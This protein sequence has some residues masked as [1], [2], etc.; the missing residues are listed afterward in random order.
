[1]RRYARLVVAL[2]S[3]TT[4]LVGGCGG[5]PAGGGWSRAEKNAEKTYRECVETEP[6]LNEIIG[7]YVLSDQTVI[8]GGLSAL[9]GRKCQ[10]DVLADGTFRVTDYP[11]FYAIVPGKS[12]TF[13]SFISTTGRWRLEVIMTS[14]YYGKKTP[15]DGWGLRFSGATRRISTPVFTGPTRPYGLLMFLGDPDSYFTLRFKRQQAGNLEEP[16]GGA[17][18]GTGS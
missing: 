18:T 4:V 9:G 8:P 3:M 10:L 2:L 17:G 14:D 1:M 12:T 11:D 7:T 5:S 6:Q 16:P 13:T 15:K